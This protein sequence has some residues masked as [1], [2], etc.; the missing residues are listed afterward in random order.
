MSQDV[1]YWMLK[2]E[3]HRLEEIHTSLLFRALDWEA[4]L[5]AER[6]IA[7]EDHIQALESEAWQHKVARLEIL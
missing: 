6:I 5:I 3:L 2:D 1:D 4:G 7:I